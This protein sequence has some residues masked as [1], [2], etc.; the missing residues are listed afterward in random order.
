MLPALERLKLFCSSG[1]MLA[2]RRLVAE[3]GLV[4]SPGPLSTILGGIGV[5][6]VRC[7]RW[8]GDTALATLRCL[9][10]VRGSLYAIVGLSVVMSVDEV[11]RLNIEI[12]EGFYPGSCG[13]TSSGAREDARPCQL[14]ALA[15]PPSHGEAR[16]Q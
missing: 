5:T 11:G 15:A 8:R 13:L 6:G 2:A 16:F 9:D 12:V 7:C 1:L 3:G 4:H 14:M 10:S